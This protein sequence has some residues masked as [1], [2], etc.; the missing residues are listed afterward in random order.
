M[1]D[2]LVY[3]V[4]D[5]SVLYCALHKLQNWVIFVVK[6]LKSAPKC[7]VWWRPL[8]L[9]CGAMVTCYCRYVNCCQSP[10]QFAWQDEA[11]L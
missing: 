5:S 6:S 8:C 1:D 10:Q 3:K 4:Q 9:H 2:G 7:Q 11:K